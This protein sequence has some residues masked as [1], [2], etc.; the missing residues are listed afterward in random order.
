[1]FPINFKEF[2]KLYPEL[3]YLSETYL[4]LKWYDYLRW[5]GLLGTK[6]TLNFRDYAYRETLL[7]QDIINR[8][9]KHK[10]TSKYNPGYN[11]STTNYISEEILNSFIKQ[12]K[13]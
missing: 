3:F 2:Y 4:M 10:V 13:L 11:I 1:M 5:Q 9:L 8:E 7:R 12:S 6:K